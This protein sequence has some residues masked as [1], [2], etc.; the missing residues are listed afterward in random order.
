M[1]MKSKAQWRFMW[2][3]HPKLAREFAEAT[4]ATYASLPEH[5]ARKKK[6]RKR[7]K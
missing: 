1:P 2:A 7:K 4:A 3:K 5:V 6:P